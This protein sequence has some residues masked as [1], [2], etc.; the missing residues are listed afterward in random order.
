[1]AY[2][3]FDLRTAIQKFSLTEDRGQDL[4]AAVPALLPSEFLQIWLT[5]FAPV[6]VGVGSEKARSEYIIMPI[7]AEARR[8]CSLSMNV[9]PGIT[10]DVDRDRGLNGFCDYVIT[11]SPEIYY[12]KGPLIAVVEAKKEDLVAG[13]GECVASMVSLRQFNEN[14]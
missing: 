3:D 1:M 8:R 5:E 2:S 7:L 13:S 9:F 12:L 11:N 4:F 6:G 14:D 10:L